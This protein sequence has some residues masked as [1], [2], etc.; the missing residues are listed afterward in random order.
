[1]RFVGVDLTS[2]FSK[3][4]RA[5]DI[6]IL[7]DTLNVKF[8]KMRWPAPADVRGR[9]IPAFQAALRA[10]VPEPHD[11]V[12]WAID[13]PQ[14]LALDGHPM[15]T[16]E[17]Q[18]GTPGR[19]PHALPDH[20]S[21]APFQGYIRSSIDLFA[22]MLAIAFKLD[23]AGDAGVALKDATLYEVFPG[24]EWAVLAGARLSSKTSQ[25]GRTER[26]QLFEHLAVQGLSALPTAD[27]ND[28]LVGAYLAWCTRHR[29]AHATLTGS[30]PVRAA[31]VDLREGYILHATP[32]AR[33][34]G[35]A[36]ARAAAPRVAIGTAPDECDRR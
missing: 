25:A 6:A 20:A 17:R 16:C 14:G 23:L 18:L 35:W 3:K 34:V 22:T 33:A 10:A 9:N 4:P 27:E 11:D 7:D 28:A 5:I 31:A 21:T 24:A 30:A 29:L 1:M 36:P 12:V 13:G 19:T 2:A 15:R 26:R 8:A 32:A